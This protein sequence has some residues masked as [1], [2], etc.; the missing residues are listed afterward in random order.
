MKKLLVIGDSISIGYTPHL[1]RH[2]DGQ[3]DVTRCEG[4]GWDSK[5]VLGRLEDY[6]AGAGDVAMILVNCGLHDIRRDRGGDG[7]QVPLADYRWNV[8]AI[9]D[10]LIAAAPTVV[11]VRTTPVDDGRHEATHDKFDRLSADVDAY[12][13]VADALAK[14]AGVPVIDLHQAVID[15]DTDT[16]IRN[17]GVHM[18]DDG[19]GLLGDYIAKAVRDMSA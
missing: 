17:D 13:A 11:W 2:L 4:N 6:L 1:R 5:N 19:Y 7:C 14:A 9:L 15:A 16:C 8:R 18:T 12:N 10:R 3:F